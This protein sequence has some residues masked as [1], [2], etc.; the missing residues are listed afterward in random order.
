LWK[1]ADQDAYEK[2][3]RGHDLFQNQEKFPSVIKTALEALCQN[4]ALGPTEIL[5]MSGF[6]N[7]HNEL[8]LTRDVENPTQPGFLRSPGEELLSATLTRY[9][10]EYCEAHI[11]KHAI[12]EEF[13]RE[14][15]SAYIST[16]ADSIPV[17][18]EFNLYDLKPIDIGK[19]LRKFL[20]VLW[21]WSWPQDQ[22]R[23]S[24]PL[25]EIFTHPEDY[26][27]TKQYTFPVA[28]A[29][30]ETLHPRDLWTLAE[31]LISIS[32]ASCLN[33]FVFRKKSDI[34]QRISSRRRYEEL[35]QSTGEE[36]VPCTNNAPGL[37]IT[38]SPPLLPMLMATNDATTIQSSAEPESSPTAES[39]DNLPEPLSMNPTPIVSLSATTSATT[40]VS[41]TSPIAPV[42]RP[43]VSASLPVA[44]VVPVITMSG[45]SMSGTPLIPASSRVALATV[46]TPGAPV[47]ESVA[48]PKL[49]AASESLAISAAPSV[50][51]STAPGP[52]TP[53]MAPEVLNSDSIVA[54]AMPVNPLTTTPLVSAPSAITL[55]LASAIVSETSPQPTRQSRRGV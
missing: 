43:L 17:L 52:V 10:C 21:F 12:P 34:M 46:V 2:K 24:I 48:A 14:V 54:N 22:E 7:A 45:D 36:I 30:I 18:L 42:S 28:L 38:D 4:G 19:I 49:S 8:V 50:L 32:G 33:P 23:P 47:D 37:P 25:L 20:N 6:R 27:D 44:P 51:G 55:P 9:W 35:M 5:F 15:E 16:N 1:A 26:Y 39:L 40:P 41:A 3:A 53:A 11:P 29:E 13:D 31:F